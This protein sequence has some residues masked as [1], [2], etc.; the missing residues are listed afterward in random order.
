VL[1]AAWA[2]ALGVDRVGRRD[3]FFDLGGHSLLATRVVAWVREALGA[4]VP[5]AELFADPTVAGLAAGL[6]AGEDGGAAAERAAELLLEIG[7]MSDAEV[8]VLASEL[9]NQSPPYSAGPRTPLAALRELDV[10][11]ATPALSRLAS[12]AREPARDGQRL[13]HELSP[14]GGAPGGEPGTA[15]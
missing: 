8:A 3:S 4:E 5:L 7:E 2:E 14:G 9:V 6:R 13:I 12:D 11:P 15:S 1:A 10:D